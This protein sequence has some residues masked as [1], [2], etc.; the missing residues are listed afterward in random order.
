MR[1]VSVRDLRSKSAQVWGQLADEKELVV[2]SNGRPIAI[3]SAVQEDRLEETLAAIRRARAMAAVDAIQQR[4][5]K[6]GL[7]DMT[8]EEINAEI[9]A[10]RKNRR[11]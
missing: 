5:A 10:V 6:M 7:A 4:A 8:L 9:A 11:R 2:T 1:F 3:L